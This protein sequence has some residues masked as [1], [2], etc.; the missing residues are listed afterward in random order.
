M[1]RKSGAVAEKRPAIQPALLPTAQAKASRPSMRALILQKLSGTGTLKTVQG[2]D[3]KLEGTLITPA[4]L[5]AVAPEPPKDW[6]KH[7]PPV[8]PTADARE[9]RR[10]MENHDYYNF[11]AME[12]EDPEKPWFRFPKHDY[13]YSELVFITPEM[14]QQ[15][16]KFM[17]TNRPQDPEWIFG[18]ARDI[19]AERWLQTHESIAFNT[20]GNFQDGQHRAEGC[21]LAGKGWVFYVT[22]NVPPEGMF[23]TDTGKKR[24]VNQQIQLVFDSKLNGKTTAVCRAMMAGLVSRGQ[25]YTAGEIAEFAVKYKE[26]IQ[27]VTD[28][29]GKYRADVQAVVGKAYLWAGKDAVDDFAT[30]LSDPLK[31]GLEDGDPV[32]ALYKWIQGAKSQR[33]P[34]VLYYRKTL[35]A[36]QAHLAGRNLK[37]V[38][39]KDHDVFEWLPGWEIPNRNDD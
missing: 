36:V 21:I 8:P 27:W 33:Q 23:A 7:W 14:F 1:P 5:P 6:P 18:I 22:W 38:W 10:A 37:K 2:E 13:Q 19:E 28:R 25:T 34:G 4:N 20:L 35:A 39:A 32:K 17:P 11:K 30:R 9:W 29:L 12:A 15:C 16:L 3:V 26:V 24:G 31:T